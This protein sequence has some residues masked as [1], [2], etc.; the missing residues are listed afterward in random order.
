[1][2]APRR[3]ARN[4][5]ARMGGEVIAKAG[6]LA[7][8]VT[9]ARELGTEGFGA[10]QFALALTTALG[11]LAGFGTDA[12]LARETARDRGRAPQLLADAAAVKLLGGALMLGVALAIVTVGGYSTTERA[13]V[14]VVGIGSVLEITSRSWFSVFQGYERLDLV[15]LVLIAQRFSTAVVGITILLAGGGILAAG[16]VY[17]G[18]AALSVVLSELTLRRLGTRRARVDRSRWGALVRAGIPIGAISLLMTL[19]LR[20]DVT[21]LSFLTDTATVGIYAVAYR[22]VEATYF[23]GSALAAAMLPWLARAHLNTA[24]GFALGLRAV[25]ALLTPVAVGFA[26]FAE[27]LIDLLYGPR[28][29]AAATPLRLM[30]AVVLMYGVNAFTGTALIARDRPLAYAKLIAPVLVINIGLNFALI[31]TYGADGAAFNAL[32]SSVLLAALALREAHRVLGRGDLNGAFAGALAGAAAM[33]AVVLALDLPWVAE[34]ILGGVAYAAGLAA[35]EWLT[36]RE[37]ARAILGA[38]AS[39]RR[40]GRTTV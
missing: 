31:P 16:A 17:A 26:L 27:P 29:E 39:R 11:Y 24:R 19:L 9:M 35:W 20:V 4:A 23:V 8:Y 32:V 36:R 14:V 34:A 5:F 33:T 12:L 22:L 3:V 28:F 13:A 1:M 40:A 37:D 7:F 10:Y 38:L 18:G 25:V 6:S 30:A 2:S 21:M 15:S